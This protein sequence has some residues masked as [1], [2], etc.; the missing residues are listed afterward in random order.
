MQVL[1]ARK[2][3]FIQNA[4]DKR[5]KSVKIVENIQTI[6]KIMCNYAEIVSKNTLPSFAHARESIMFIGF[7]FY[8]VLTFLTFDQ[9]E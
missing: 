9:D 6:Y 8:F 7:A 1:F 2:F 5:I 4:D 3:K